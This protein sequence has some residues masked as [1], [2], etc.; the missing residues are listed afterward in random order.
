MSAAETTRAL[1]AAVARRYPSAQGWIV[2]REVENPLGG[3]ADAVAIHYRGALRVVGFEFK[4]T[5]DDWREELARPE[6]SAWWA[7]RCSE[8]YLVVPDKGFVEDDG[9]PPPSWGVLTMDPGEAVLRTFI[10]PQRRELWEGPHED[11][12]CALFRAAGKELSR[13]PGAA[14]IAAERGIAKEKGVEETVSR[15]RALLDKVEKEA[16]WK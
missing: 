5:R 7:L 4:A 6:K 15:V 8:F 1:T 14:E 2:L 11:L 9:A 3:R 13:S 10:S 16:K 12:L